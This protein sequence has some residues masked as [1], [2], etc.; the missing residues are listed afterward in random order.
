MR[1]IRFSS[2]DR[3]M[4]VKL[5]CRNHLDIRHQERRLQMRAGDPLFDAHIGD[6]DLVH[7]FPVFLVTSG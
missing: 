4:F 5:V 1:W 6:A 2:L 3:L 7:Q